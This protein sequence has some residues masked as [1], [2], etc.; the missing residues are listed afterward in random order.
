MNKPG[1]AICTRCIMDSTDPEITFDNEGHCNHCNSALAQAPEIWFPDENGERMLR[2]VIERIRNEG[3]GKEYDCIVGLS[4]GIDSSYLAY[5]TKVKLELRPLV[6][7]VDC[8]WNS[9][10]A[11][12]NIENI[13]KHLDLELH[14][15]VV[16]WEEM[17]D[18][19]RAFFKASLPDQDI[20]QDHAIFA[21]LYKFASENDVRYAL[22]G[23]NY[24]T[25]IILPTSW[26]YQ[27]MDLRQI[28]SVHKHFGE[29]PLKD[30]PTVNFLERYIY[31]KFIRRMNILSPLN[32]FNYRKEE[33]IDILTRELGWKYYGGKHYES[34]FTKFFQSY[35][36]PYKFNFDKRRAHLSSLVISGQM[37]RSEALEAMKE[38]SY[39]ENEINDDIDY[40]AKKLDWSPQEFRNIID[41]PPREHREF[42][43]LDHLFNLGIKAKRMVRKILS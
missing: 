4:G 24:S 40:V 26:G 38:F 7:H 14:T 22:N 12:K 2:K 42:A 30:F 17:K 25:E 5:L 39:S 35:Y 31:Y 10:L 15:F 20:P 28:K 19:Q 33:A 8:G 16:N 43:N 9:E 13:T 18:L 36:L 3:K 21:A 41:L 37:K 29:R 11:V 27:A 23:G 1:Y 6:V 32:Y 34:R